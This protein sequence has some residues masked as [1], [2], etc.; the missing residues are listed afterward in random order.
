R[1]GAK[2]RLGGHERSRAHRRPDPSDATHGRL[3]PT[4]VGIA[5]SVRCTNSTRVVSIHG[6]AIASTATAATIFG[7]ND[8]VDSW[9]WVAAW[10][11]LTTRPTPSTVRRMGAETISRM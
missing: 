7:T 1:A 2:R 11:M 5:C 3:Q 9:I 6:P 4:T 10:K 8:K